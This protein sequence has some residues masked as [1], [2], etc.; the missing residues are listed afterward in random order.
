MA[1]RVPFTVVIAGAAASA[2]VLPPPVTAKLLLRSVATM[3][4]SAAL[5]GPAE[6]LF[7][8]VTAL[9]PA[10]WSPVTAFLDV[11]NV[12]VVGSLGGCTRSVTVHS[13]LA[14]R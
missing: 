10:Y 3:S 7:A 8:T 2:R 9:N 11:M 14:T 13:R 1:M 12:K 4:S 6:W 5:P